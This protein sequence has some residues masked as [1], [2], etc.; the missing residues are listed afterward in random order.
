MRLNS[1]NL[2]L[3][4]L[5]ITQPKIKSLAEVVG[6]KAWPAGHDNQISTVG[7]GERIGN[8]RSRTRLTGA[9]GNYVAGTNRRFLKFSVKVSRDELKVVPLDTPA[10]YV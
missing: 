2:T 6:S 8:Y 9:N 3:N 5:R 4:R 7:L 1:S 10:P